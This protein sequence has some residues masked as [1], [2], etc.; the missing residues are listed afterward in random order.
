MLVTIECQCISR[1]KTAHSLC[2]EWSSHKHFKS[3]FVRTGREAFHIVMTKA[4]L[5]P[6]TTATTCCHP[7]GCTHPHPTLS[8]PICSQCKQSHSALC[9]ADVSKRDPFTVL[10]AKRVLSWFRVN[11]THARPHGIKLAWRSR[12][13]RLAEFQLHRIGWQCTK[14]QGIYSGIRTESLYENN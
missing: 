6:S 9:S 3:P 8:H 14:R 12:E 13:F 1:L 5:Q 2:Q 4:F 10:P 11:F 7:E